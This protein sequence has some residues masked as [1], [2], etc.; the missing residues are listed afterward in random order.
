MH[1]TRATRNVLTLINANKS[2]TKQFSFPNQNNKLYTVICFYNPLPNHYDKKKA[3][4]GQ[5]YKNFDRDI[6]KRKWSA[7]YS[8]TFTPQQIRSEAHTAMIMQTEMLTHF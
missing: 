6:R 7:S 3:N 5:N 1:K 2:C 8:S 4:V